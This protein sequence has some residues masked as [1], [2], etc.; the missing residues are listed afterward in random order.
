MWN[1]FELYRQVD[2]VR[3]FRE[4]GEQEFHSIAVLARQRLG[5]IASSAYQERVF[6]TASFVMGP[7]RTRTENFRAENQRQCLEAY[8]DCDEVEAAKFLYYTLYCLF[9]ANKNIL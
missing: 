5:K 3:W 9:F 8:L 4:V 2:I 1:L 7:L 6:S